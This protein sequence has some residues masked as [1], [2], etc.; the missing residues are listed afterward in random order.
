MVFDHT[1]CLVDCDCKTCTTRIDCPLVWH[2]DK[3]ACG[4]CEHEGYAIQFTRGC[5]WNKAKEV[6]DGHS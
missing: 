5:N 1:T 3:N 4:L 2:E 6:V